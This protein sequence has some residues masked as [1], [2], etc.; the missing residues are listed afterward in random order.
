MDRQS[1]GRKGGWDQ[2][3]TENQVALC[4]APGVQGSWALTGLDITAA[5]ALILRAERASFL[6]ISTW[7]VPLSLADIPCSWQFQNLRNLLE[8]KASFITY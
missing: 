1:T 5:M 3:K 8:A 4:Q 7:A 2:K 6:D